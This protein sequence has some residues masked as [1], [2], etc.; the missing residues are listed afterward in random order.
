MCKVTKKNKNFRVSDG[1][2]A[3]DLL[4]YARDHLASAELL[5]KRNPLCYDSGGY[6]AHL[7]L[8]LTLKSILLKL[9]REFP[10]EHDLKTLYNLAKKSGAIPIK[11]DEEKILKKIS[12]FFR[13][14]YANPQ[15]PIEIGNDDWEAIERLFFSLLLANFPN[16]ILSK[17]DDCNHYKKGNRVLMMK[18]KETTLPI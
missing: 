6:L 9:N 10:V 15:R 11:E 5:F 17:L 3:K 13:L 7:G 12:Q 16:D 14:R 2:E 1:F 4:K 18:L 8:E